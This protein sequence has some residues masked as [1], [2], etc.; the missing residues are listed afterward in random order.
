MR[1]KDYSKDIGYQ[2][3]QRMVPRSAGIAV[4][5][6]ILIGGS[7]ALYAARPPEKKPAPVQKFA[8]VAAPTETAE[9]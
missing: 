6:A 9:K 4:I 3:E 2:T 7:A 8:P 1:S 5:A